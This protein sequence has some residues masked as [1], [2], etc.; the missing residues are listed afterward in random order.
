MGFKLDQYHVLYT[1]PT[2]FYEKTAGVD[3]VLTA[4]LG[5]IKTLGIIDNESEYKLE[6]DQLLTDSLG[7]EHIASYKMDVKL[8]VSSEVTA[9][10]LAD[11]DGKY[12]TLV[13]VPKSVKIPDDAT[14][15]SDADVAGLDA[16]KLI[17]FAPGI[18]KVQESVKIGS[19]K[20]NPIILSVATTDV[21]K[22]NLKKEF[23]VDLTP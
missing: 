17:Y 3:K 7:Y 14:D 13:L 18:I 20:I 21:L 10:K 5:A 1:E 16:K 8:N 19:T 23:E 2:F 6:P 12:L 22:S 15:L 9:A 11:V 4:N